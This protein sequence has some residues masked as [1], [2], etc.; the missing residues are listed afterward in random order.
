MVSGT[1]VYGGEGVIDMDLFQEDAYHSRSARGT[2]N[3]IVD[4][5]EG[6]RVIKGGSWSYEPEGLEVSYRKHLATHFKT[7]RIGFRIARSPKLKKK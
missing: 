5:V 1:L 2:T 3:P 7:S 4:G 6:P